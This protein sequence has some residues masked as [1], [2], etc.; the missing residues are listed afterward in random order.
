VEISGLIADSQFKKSK[1]YDKV[2]NLKVKC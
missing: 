2:H 1:T